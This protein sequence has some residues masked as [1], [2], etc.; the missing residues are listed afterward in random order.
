M[1][2]TLPI[3]RHDTRRLLSSLLEIHSNLKTVLP[4][5]YQHVSCPTR[6]DKTLDHV[7]H[8]IKEAYKALSLPHLGQSDHISLFL[9]PKYHPLIRRVKPSVKSVKV[10]PEGADLKHRLQHSNWTDF[11]VTDT[12]HLNT[13]IDSYT[14]SVLDYIKN[15]KQRPP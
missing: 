8:N 4:K 13:D 7:Y 11:A 5:F 1:Q 9:L 3:N 15:N 2:P 12:V 10:W 6:G 14:S